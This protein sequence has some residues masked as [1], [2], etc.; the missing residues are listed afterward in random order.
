VRDGF[1]DFM[2]EK[3]RQV[4]HGEKPDSNMFPFIC[5]LDKADQ[6]NDPD[7]WE[8]ANPMFSH[9]RS[10]YAQTLYETVY[11]EFLDLEEDPSG[12]E[13]F[14]T[15]RM[16]FPETDLQR[17]V[18]SVEEINATNRPFPPLSHLPCVGG[19]DFASIR[20]FAAVGLLFKVGED[21]VWKTHSFVRQGFLDMVKLKPPIHEW[22]K[23]GLLTIV[24]E[25]TIGIR[26]IVDWFVEMRE[27]YGLT[28]IVADNFRLDLVRTALEAEG[29]E[30]VIIRNPKAAHALLAPRIET[31]FANKRIIFGPNPLM[32]WYTNNVLVSIRKDGNKEYLKKDEIRRKTD[33]FQAMV[34]ALWSADDILEEEVEFILDDIAF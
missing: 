9:P 17:S 7:L 14:M 20:D 25:P 21:Y 11:E 16:N 22:E 10:E 27:Q 34:H 18:A 2:K 13:D 8:L 28:T 29:F 1:L 30:L 32:R 6:V 31:M 23:Q 33:G 26:H 12:R 3:A 4:L 19:L 15:K 5:K 24:D